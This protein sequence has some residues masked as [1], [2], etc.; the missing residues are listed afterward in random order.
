M[1]KDRT[2]RFSCSLEFEALSPDAKTEYTKKFDE[3]K[4]LMEHTNYSIRDDS[5]LVFKF[6]T[7]ELPATVTAE[8]VA[9]ELMC[10]Q[11]ICDNFGYHTISEE[12]LREMAS[13]LRDR[14]NLSW[15][16]VW[17]LLHMFGCD[18]IKYA[19]MKSCLPE[20]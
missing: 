18:A 9:H 2:P 12:V 16:Q 6:C 3:V 17:N 1:S 15:S 14:Y 4:R 19:C 20:F 7:H 11:Y 5:R 13:I 10:I 8:N